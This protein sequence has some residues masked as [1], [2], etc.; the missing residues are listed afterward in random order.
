MTADDVDEA[1]AL[2]ITD[3]FLATLGAGSAQD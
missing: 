2:S 1:Y 3:A